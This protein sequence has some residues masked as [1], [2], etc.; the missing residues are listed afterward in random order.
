MTVVWGVV[1][2][3]VGV[4]I[5]AQLMFPDLTYGISWLSYGR[6]R[7][8]HTNAVIFAFGGSALFATS[9][10]VVQRTCHTRLFSDKL[11]AF[12]FWGW[13]LVIVLAAITLPLGITTSKE[14]A[15]LEWPI[16]VLITLV[17][18]SYAIVFF[19][20]LVKR[21]VSHIYVANWFFGAFILTVAL[22]HLVNSAA[23]P[24]SFWKSYS[25]YAGVQ[26]AMV[27]WWYGHN[28]VGFFLTAG[29]LGIMYYF[30]PKQAERP[31]F[32][33]RLSVVHFWALIFTYMW[34]GPHHLHYT[35]LPDWAQSIGM[36]FSLILLAPSW[37]GMINGIMTLSGAWHKLRTDPI[38]KFLIVSLSF[39]GMSTFEGPMMSIKTVN[40]LSHY[41][42][43]TIGHVHSG[44]LGWV[45]FISIGAIYY[46][47]PRLFGKTEMHSTR[48]ITVHFWIATLGVVLYI[49][50][51]WIAG[52]M[53][54]LM[55]RAVNPDGTLTY[56]FVESV[57]ATFPFYTIRLLG[58]LM[59]FAGMLIMVYNVWKTIAGAKPVDA[60][61]V[62]PAAAHA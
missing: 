8:L 40:S 42:D 45:A 51:M 19:G 9:Y 20:T 54:G 60:T 61:V 56:T 17:W 57:K 36:V 30:V 5:A 1:G 13:Q 38:L 31:I 4:I 62:A 41:T 29:F 55:W 14:Y 59:F 52:V 28:A 16:D 49:A 6:L 27:Q 35:A 10:F 50:A 24:V 37:G 58:G 43:W 47:I 2:M 12:T 34:A 46:M 23:I 25:V 11:A 44:A 39:Y 21:R 18:V 48:L 3:L 53:Q 33:Y 22:L 7:P 26:D 15:E 32:S